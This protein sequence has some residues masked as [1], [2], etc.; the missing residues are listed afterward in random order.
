M[1]RVMVFKRAMTINKWWL[2][3]SFADHDLH[4][5][6]QVTFFDLVSLS[7]FL[8]LITHCFI[9][10]SLEQASHG[11][12]QRAIWGILFLTSSSRSR[13]QGCWLKSSF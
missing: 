7:L 13:F 8:R 3:W 12:W 6:A 10:L 2:A 5:A 11:E 1:T 9:Q 4:P